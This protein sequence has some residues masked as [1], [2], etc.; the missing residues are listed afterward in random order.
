M[1]S[2]I[3]KTSGKTLDVPFE[4]IKDAVLGKRYDLSLAL[5]LPKEARRITLHTKQKDKASD[6]LSFPL[7]ATSGEIFLCPS[8][9]RTNA[10]AYTRAYEKHLAHLLIHGLLHLKGFEHSDT[11]DDKE[12]RIAR[13]FGY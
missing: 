8:T 5:I 2:I 13:R 10:R 6:V 11:M 3:N 1:F 4:K 12:D 7:S 9:I